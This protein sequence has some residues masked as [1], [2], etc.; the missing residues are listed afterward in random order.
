MD[1]PSTGVERSLAMPSASSFSRGPA[2]AG[3]GLLAG[4]TGLSRS[5][6]IAAGL[7]RSY[8]AGIAGKFSIVPLTVEATPDVACAL[9]GKDGVGVRACIVR[10]GAAV[11][12]SIFAASAAAEP[13]E[14]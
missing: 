9:T 5:F 2:Q 8:P 4:E 6:D 14:G 11:G 3:I 12:V 7:I 13:A 10:P 1:G